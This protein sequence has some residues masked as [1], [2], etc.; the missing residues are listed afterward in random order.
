MDIQK[1]RRTKSVDKLQYEIR[2]D[3]RG[4]R[5]VIISFRKKRRSE[6][7]G[8][9]G[10]RQ[11][12]PGTF[13]HYQRQVSEKYSGP[14]LAISKISEQRGGGGRTPPP[15]PPVL[16]R[17]GVG[18]IP[19]P[20]FQELFFVPIQTSPVSRNPEWRTWAELRVL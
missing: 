3:F 2:W 13:F 19:P 12:I 6:F 7:F 10:P 14:K 8:C 1:R 5:G 16:G 9:F 20:L 15:V 4:A 11:P 17:G 18:G